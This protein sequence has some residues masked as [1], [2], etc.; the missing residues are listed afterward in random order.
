MATLPTRAHATRQLVPHIS[1]AIV[2]ARHTS[3]IRG[4]RRSS[5]GLNNDHG[6]LHDWI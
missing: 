5:E 6:D 3:K 2:C 4:T 1:S